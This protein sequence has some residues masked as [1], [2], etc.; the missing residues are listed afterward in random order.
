MTIFP[1]GNV[2]ADVNEPPLGTVDDSP[3]SIVYKEI[4]EGKSWLRIRKQ[5]PCNGCVYQ[6]LCPSPSNY[7]TIIG[8]QN[9][10]HLKVDN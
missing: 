1:N 2:Y 6:W 8:Q 5:A 10:C 7:E 3:L 9:L 4:S